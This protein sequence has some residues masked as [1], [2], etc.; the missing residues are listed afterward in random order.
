[1]ELLLILFFF[2][3]SAGLIGRI[4]GSSFLIWFLIGFC[5]PF[6]GTLAALLWRFEQRVPRRPC[7]ECGN[8]LALHDQVCM[9]CG[10]D[11]E[12]PEQL[13]AE[14]ESTA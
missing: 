4:K 6:F 10:R 7:P 3:L 11:L 14:R 8:S 12:F 13:V 2:G 5:I 9:H 1:M